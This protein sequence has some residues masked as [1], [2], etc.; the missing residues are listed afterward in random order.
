MLT[1]P[2]WRPATRAEI[3]TFYTD[4]FSNRTGEI[5][6]WVTPPKP[7]EFAVALSTRFP[8]TAG[9][10]RE[11]LRRSTTSTGNTLTDW[12]A[13][14][15][16]FARP[17]ETDPL[18][19]SAAGQEATPLADPDTVAAT[20]PVTEAAY[21]GLDNT[22]RFWVLAFD[23]DAKDVAIARLIS[24]SATDNPAP[25]E[26]VA[27]S[28]IA[29]EPPTGGNETTY[30][31]TFDD[32]Q[33]AIDAGFEL[34]D[35]LQ[36]HCNYDRVRVF[37]SGQGVHVYALDQDIDHR[38][39]T[40]TRKFLAPYIKERAGIPIDTRVTTDE[41]RVLRVPRSLHAGVNRLV[42]ELDSPEFDPRTDPRALPAHL[43]ADTETE[44]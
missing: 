35:L 4:E 38:Y 28:G 32:I 18:R 2:P 8:T 34:Q 27:D 42:T 5:P 33:T 19:A 43:T 25:T 13:V 3:R 39:T 1:D 36:T 12:E 16:F 29:D 22:D 11:F 21:Y 17:A 6:S 7:T 24:E 30:N 15:A 14:T 20:P 41:R 44:Q 31:Y 37:Y 26:V 40:Q 23:I 10:D 9:N